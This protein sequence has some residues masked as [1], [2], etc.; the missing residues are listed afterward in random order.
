MEEELIFHDYERFVNKMFEKDFEL[1]REM[2][3]ESV[4]DYKENG[5]DKYINLI[6]LNLKRIIKSR[7]YKVFE[8]LNLN[9]SQ[10][11]NAIKEKK[12]DRNIINKM[13]EVLEIKERI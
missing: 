5:N 12:Y 1:G 6:L 8:E 3:E 2:L 10:I 9:E 13:L 4:H 7:G 11:N